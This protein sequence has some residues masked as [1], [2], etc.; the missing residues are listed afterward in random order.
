[1]SLELGAQPQKHII[2]SLIGHRYCNEVPFADTASSR[3]SL[4]L[5]D[6]IELQIAV[7]GS[8]VIPLSVTILTATPRAPQFLLYV[9]VMN[10]LPICAS[11]CALAHVVNNKL[12]VVLA[13]CDRLS[14]H[15]TDQEV[16]AGLR[17]I[18]MA[19]QALADEFNKP[20]RRGQGA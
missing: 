11:E 18:H 9:P 6:A 13:M 12:S 16:L 20:L 15:T 3:D 7:M 2:R 17:V 19:A 14:E 4:T 10:K 8:H 5:F 1:V